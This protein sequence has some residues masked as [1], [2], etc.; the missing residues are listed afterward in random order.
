MSEVWGEHS[1]FLD[2]TFQQESLQGKQT[3]TSV[4]G[5]QDRRTEYILSLCLCVCVHAPGD[6]C[7]TF[8]FSFCLLHYNINVY[9]VSKSILINAH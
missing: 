9:D 6:C 7:S 1:H 2:L 8:S 4:T 5:K 3:V